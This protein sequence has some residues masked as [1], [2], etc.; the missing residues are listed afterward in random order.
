MVA[1]LQKLKVSFIYNNSRFLID[2][3]CLTI[4]FRVFSVRYTGNF[5]GMNSV[6]IYELFYE[7]NIIMKIGKNPLSLR[8]FSFV[9][10]WALVL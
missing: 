9:A 1:N 2:I 6:K 7:S 4:S 8:N 5:R 3:P 10:H